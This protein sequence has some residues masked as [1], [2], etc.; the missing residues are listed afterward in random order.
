MAAVE[1]EHVTYRYGDLVAVN[2]LTLIIS[3]GA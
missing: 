2:D 3:E 1:A